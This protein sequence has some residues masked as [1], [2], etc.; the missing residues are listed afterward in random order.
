[1]VVAQ[2]MAYPTSYDGNDYKIEAV[3]E[4]K[5]NFTE[6]TYKFTK[7]GRTSSHIVFAAPVGCI[8]KDLADL[9][10]NTSFLYNEKTLDLEWAATTDPSCGIGGST[11]Y[12]AKLDPAPTESYFEI[13]VNIADLAVG[14]SSGMLTIKPGKDCQTFLLEAIDCPDF[15]WIQEA[16]IAEKRVIDKDGGEICL[17]SDPRTQCDVAVNCE[18]GD[19]IEGIPVQQALQIGVNPVLYVA[20]PGAACQTFT[21]DDGVDGATRYYCSGGICYPY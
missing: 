16:V 15:E 13:K 4:K 11:T 19:P 12:I 10:T 1:L 8:G 21:V 20:V 14:I 18:T 5:T 17:R 7:V 6:C 9:N 2:V 3:C